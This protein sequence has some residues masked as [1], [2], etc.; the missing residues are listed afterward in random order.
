[1]LNKYGNVWCSDVNAHLAE[2]M[3]MRFG[4]SMWSLQK[5]AEIGFFI[6]FIK[7]MN[8]MLI[9]LQNIHQLK[10]MSSLRVI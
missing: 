7:H 3:P 10:K 6:R 5:Q 1:M 8:G 9:R 2:T 4:L